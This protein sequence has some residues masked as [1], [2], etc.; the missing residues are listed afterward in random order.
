MREIFAGGC[1]PKHTIVLCLCVGR[2]NA[3]RTEVREDENSPGYMAG[4]VLWEAQKSEETYATCRLVRRDLEARG[5]RTDWKEAWTR[6]ARVAGRIRWRMDPAS[7]VEE[8]G[9]KRHGEKQGSESGFSWMM[10]ARYR[11]KNETYNVT[12]PSAFAQSSISR[13]C[14]GKNACRKRVER[15]AEHLRRGQDGTGNEGEER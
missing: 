14:I 1:V 2:Y 13:P 3:G 5:P 6:N 9:V 7:S 15:G 10:K 8:D 12:N 4:W 11:S